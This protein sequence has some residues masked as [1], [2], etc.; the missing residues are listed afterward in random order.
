MS[1]R[2]ELD[3]LIAVI[4]P[5]GDTSTYSGMKPRQSAEKEHGPQMPGRRRWILCVAPLCLCGVGV[6][7]DY[8]GAWYL[9]RAEVRWDKTISRDRNTLDSYTRVVVVDEPVEQNAAA[10]YRLAFAKLPAQSAEMHKALFPVA[11]SNAEADSATL[12]VLMADWCGEAPKVRVQRA[13]RCTHCDWELGYSPEPDPALN[14]WFQALT[15]S[16][17]LVLGGHQR[18]QQHDWRQAIRSYLQTL[19]LGRDL[20]QGSVEMNA[21]GMSAA[22]WALRGLGRSAGYITDQPLL[23]ELSKQL[24]RFNGTLPSVATGLRFFRLQVATELRRT[25]G[26]YLAPGQNGLSRLV[27]W[28]ALGAWRFSREEAMLG[29]NARIA[30]LGQLTD[31]RERQRVISEIATPGTRVSA[32]VPHSLPDLLR[33][34]DDLAR[35][36]RAVRVALTLQDWYV[37]HGEYP[38]DARPLQILA[39]DDALKYERSRDAQGYRLI[40]A[41]GDDMTATL[42]ERRTVEY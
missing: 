16:E 32:T 8:S 18:A 1:C 35:L 3:R 38:V 9:R 12:R 28:R 27:P 33:R 42:L 20:G 13:F 31:R 26:A 11:E 15:L 29:P 39:G 25:A 14:N 30:E 5:T 7:A 6:L 37:V 10:W 17:C 40:G 2:D 23:D 34:G 24:A 21:V 36:Y 41:K 19:S 22:T 4:T